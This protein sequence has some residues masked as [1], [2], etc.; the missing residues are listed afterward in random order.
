MVVQNFSY[1]PARPARPSKPAHER[2]ERSLSSRRAGSAGLAGLAKMQFSIPGCKLEPPLRVATT[3]LH[4]TFAALYDNELDF[5]GAQTWAA[6]AC[7]GRY[8]QWESVKS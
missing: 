6:R 7:T 3:K 2:K 8:S 5:P 1:R 4:L